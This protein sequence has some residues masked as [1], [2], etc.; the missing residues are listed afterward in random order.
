MRVEFLHLYSAELNI[1]NPFS[2][3]INKI[4]NVIYARCVYVFALCNG[5]LTSYCSRR[6]SVNSFVR[7]TCRVTCKF[8]I[9]GRAMT[10][11]VS[12]QL[13]IAEAWDQ[14]HVAL[15]GI[16]GGQ[17]GTNISPSSV[18]FCRC[19]STIIPWS[20][21]H[22][23]SIVRVYDLRDGNNTHTDSLIVEMYRIMLLAL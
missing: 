17:S 8:P 5:S 9:N 22:V 20:F 12:H 14:Y 1:L 21:I 7:D 16:C 4:D 3:V 15:C 10:R 11:M 18:F 19:Y 2:V 23:S 13:C 6:S